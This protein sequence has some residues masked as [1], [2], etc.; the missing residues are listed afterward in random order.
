VQYRSLPGVENVRAGFS[1]TRLLLSGNVD[2]E[3]LCVKALRRW[4]AGVAKAELEPRLRALSLV[5]NTP[6]GKMQ[7]RAQ[8]TCWGSRSS[9]G[10]VSLNLCLLFLEP[11]VVRYLMIHE[12]CHG[13]H[14]NHSK[15]F[16]ASGGPLRAGLPASRPRAHRELATCTRMDGDLLIIYKKI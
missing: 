6:Y 8:R 14:M 15:R 4:L 16:W 3:Q 5:M 13:R 1:G 9:S 11:Q 2:D 10:T 7:I 12:L